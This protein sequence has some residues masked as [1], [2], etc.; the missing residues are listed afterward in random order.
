MSNHKYCKN[1]GQITSHSSIHTVP[2][3]LDIQN[4]NN[5]VD[6]QA[7]LENADTG[8]SGSVNRVNINQEFPT[9]QQTC[10]LN[11]HPPQGQGAA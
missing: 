2:H 3:G 4:K 7:A 6:F 11:G 9:P 1:L 8:S 10:A 5:K